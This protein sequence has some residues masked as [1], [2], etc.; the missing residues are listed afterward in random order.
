MVGLSATENETAVLA[1]SGKVHE[2]HPDT[3][4]RFFI[5]GASH[6]I[7]DYYW[8][9]QNTTVWNWITYMITDDPKWKEI[10]E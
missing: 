7:P 4:K 6:C 9:V 5:K 10:L 2:A 1:A 8:K 3:F